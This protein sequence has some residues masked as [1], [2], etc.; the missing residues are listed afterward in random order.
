MGALCRGCRGCRSDIGAFRRLDS[1]PLDQRLG[2]GQHRR[3]RR[4]CRRLRGGGELRIRFRPYVRSNS[5]RVGALRPVRPE[6]GCRRG[7]LVRLRGGYGRRGP[8]PVPGRRR[9]PGG[10]P[11]CSRRGARLHFGANAPRNAGRDRARGLDRGSVPALRRLG[12]RPEQRLRHVDA[13]SGNASHRARLPGG[14]HHHRHDP[15]GRPPAR[16]PRGRRAHAAA[17][18]RPGVQRAR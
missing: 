3:H 12:R 17:D 18:R 4:G 15:G 7:R 11:V 2:N 16:A 13:V 5:R 9:I 10:D 1:G 14:G 6:L 8:V